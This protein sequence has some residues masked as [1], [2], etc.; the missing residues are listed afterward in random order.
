MEITEQDALVII[1]IISKT[2]FLPN[3]YEQVV[4]PLLIK[5]QQAQQPVTP[6]GAQ[7]M[8]KRISEE[9]KKKHLEKKK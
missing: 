1:N 3:E 5:L 9:L 2:A 4:K 6:T 8:K 7:E